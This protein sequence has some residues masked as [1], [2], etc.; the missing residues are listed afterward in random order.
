MMERSEMID[1]LSM[2]YDRRL[3]ALLCYQD[4]SFTQGLVAYMFQRF[5]EITEDGQPMFNLVIQSYIADVLRYGD[6]AEN[7]SGALLA[8]NELTSNLENYI[9][10]TVFCFWPDKKKELDA[11]RDGDK[12]F[13][14]RSFIGERFRNIVEKYPDRFPER[15]SHPNIVSQLRHVT[16]IRNRQSHPMRLGYTALFD[17]YQYLKAFDVLLGYLLYTY[18]HLIFAGIDLQMNYLNKQT[19]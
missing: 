15:F 6:S 10:C 11:Y 8:L 3:K 13:D 19:I 12:P 14:S 18:Y 2:L 5:D 16:E 7:H 17:R 4:A 9:K 1:A